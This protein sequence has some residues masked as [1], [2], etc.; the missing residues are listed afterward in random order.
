MS[1]KIRLS[2]R[3]TCESTSRLSCR[4]LFSLGNEHPARVFCVGVSH[5]NVLTKDIPPKAN[6]FVSTAERNLFFQPRARLP[7]R[8]V[9]GRLCEGAVA[10]LPNGIAQQDSA[11]MQVG[12]REH[13]SMRSEVK[14]S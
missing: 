1:V 7:F 12:L 8:L 6:G 10:L 2:H 5:T 11:V 13:R 3:W 9:P 14:G 4:C